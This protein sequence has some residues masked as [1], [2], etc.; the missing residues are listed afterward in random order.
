VRQGENPEA[1]ERLFAEW[2]RRKGEAS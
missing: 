2:E 1:F